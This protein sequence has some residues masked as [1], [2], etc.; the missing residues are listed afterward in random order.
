MHVYSWLVS[1]SLFCYC[2]SHSPSSPSLLNEKKNQ[3]K[4]LCLRAIFL[5]VLG[6]FFRLVLVYSRSH[7]VLY[8]TQPSKKEL[9]QRVVFQQHNSLIGGPTATSCPVCHKLCLGG[10][11]LMEH[12]KITHKD[13]NASG[14]ASKYLGSTIS[15]Y[16]DILKVFAY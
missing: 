14:V 16:G 9:Q 8:Y 11:A 7:C 6:G 10:E 2:W 15:S 13:P 5:V 4:P 12:M 1:C 3:K